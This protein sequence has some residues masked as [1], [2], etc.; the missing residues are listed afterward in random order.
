MNYNENYEGIKLD[1]QAVD[2]T[3]DKIVEE[4]IRHVLVRLLRFTEKII[5]ANVYLEDKQ[6]KSNDQKSVKIHLGIPGNEFFASESG[7]DFYTLLGVVEDKLIRQFQ[8][9]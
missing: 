5:W 8:K 9:K 2:I 6:G 1:V 7:D 4:R 3:V